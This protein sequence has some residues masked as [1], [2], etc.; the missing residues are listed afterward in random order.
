MRYTRSAVISPCAGVATCCGSDWASGCGNLCGKTSLITTVKILFLQ[1]VYA[2]SH[3]WM[4][5]LYCFI[6]KMRKEP[7]VEN[8]IV[9]IQKP[10]YS[11][12]ICNFSIHQ[13][14]THWL[15]YC[16][17]YA[18]GGCCYHTGWNV[19]MITPALRADF[20][21]CKENIRNWNFLHPLVIVIIYTS[22]RSV[23]KTW[24]DRCAI[25]T[26]SLIHCGRT[27]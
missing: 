13:D 10:R 12:I 8:S 9:V 19:C 25:N 18:N 22:Q 11:E 15:R 17:Q 24:R 7:F 27:P 16:K 14:G 21:W 20:L 6:H 26:A 23:N 4:C 2:D 5:V 1:E 3:I